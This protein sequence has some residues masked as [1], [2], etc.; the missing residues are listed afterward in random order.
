MS[1][2]VV[3]N[4]EVMIENTIKRKQ[5]FSACEYHQDDHHELSMSPFY[6]MIDM[7]SCCVMVFMFVCSLRHQGGL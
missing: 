4:K 6:I 5:D 3:V 7:Y 1:T 2:E